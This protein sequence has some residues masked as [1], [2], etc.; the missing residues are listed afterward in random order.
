M[1]FGRRELVQRNCASA[2]E[3]QPTWGCPRSRGISSGAV[4]RYCTGIGHQAEYWW[5]TRSRV[6]EK[7]SLVL[8]VVHRVSKAARQDQRDAEGEL[9]EEE[10]REVKPKIVAKL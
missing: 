4:K 7:P 6:A 1:V 10:G 8:T 5:R 9:A 2:V 3:F